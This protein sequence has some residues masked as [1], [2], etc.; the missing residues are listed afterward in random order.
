MVSIWREVVLLMWSTMD[1]RVVDLPLP[2]GPVTKTSPLG[3]SESSLTTSGR[4]SWENVGISCFNR[5]ML[6]AK[7]LR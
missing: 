3:I 6:A 5:R 4:P 7:L 1:A 2:V